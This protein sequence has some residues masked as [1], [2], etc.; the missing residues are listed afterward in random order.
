MRKDKFP[1]KGEPPVEHVSEQQIRRTH[2]EI[3]D[4]SGELPELDLH[5]QTSQEAAL[6]VY[7][8]IDR[9]AVSGEPCCRIIHGK[10]TGVL[11]RAVTKEIEE[12][13]EQGIIEAWFRS[14]KYPGAAIVVIF[15]AELT[16][17]ININL[18]LCPNLHPNKWLSTRNG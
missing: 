17:T 9:M 12:L 7:G 11:E 5:G 3:A 10:G 13:T 14:Q 6:N 18:F 8:Y 1:N 2:A 16:F 4:Q 15:R